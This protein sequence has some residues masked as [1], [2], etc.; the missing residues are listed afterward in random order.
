MKSAIRLAGVVASWWWASSWLIGARERLL[1][2]TVQQP[3]VD[4]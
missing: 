4:Q 2:A 3:V 1:P